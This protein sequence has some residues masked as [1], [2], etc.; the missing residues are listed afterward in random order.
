MTEK[1]YK[2]II[3]LVFTITVSASV[4]LICTDNISPFT[5]QATIHKSIAYIAPEV[6][7]VTI[8]VN[9]KNGQHVNIGDTL[10]TLDNK[11]YALAV[12]QAKAELH[13]AKNA[14]TAIWQELQVAKQIS[15]QRQIEWKNAKTKQIRYKRLLTNSVITKQEYD[16]IALNANVAKSALGAAKSDILRIKAELSGEA[17]SAIIELATVKLA[18]AELDLKRTNVV[19]QT[20]GIVSNLQLDSGTYANKGSVLLLIVNDD[21]TWLTADFN[22]KGIDRLQTGT[23]VWVAFDAIPGRLFTGKIMNKERAIFDS[24]NLSNR[25]SEVVNTTRWIREQQKIRTN[26]HLE[27]INSALFSGSRASVIVENGNPI[28]DAIGYLWI[29]VVSHFRYIY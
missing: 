16:D 4:F 1:I 19:A 20:S 6:S 23:N 13:Q 29:N 11:I 27:N 9:I 21:K 2:F 17:P 10:F 8:K 26:I 12:R 7:G 28:I 14:D 25:L 5:T 22:E 24:Y 15:L 18:R 3:Y